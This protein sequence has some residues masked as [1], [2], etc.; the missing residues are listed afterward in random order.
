M[1]PVAG[2]RRDVA[3]R[4]GE[5]SNDQK[6]FVPADQSRDRVTP[7][8]YEI[9]SGGGKHFAYTVLSVFGKTPDEVEAIRAR[10]QPWLAAAIGVAVPDGSEPA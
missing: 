5:T 6:I 4:P 7:V 1:R 8:E 9:R 2:Q 10:W 3:A